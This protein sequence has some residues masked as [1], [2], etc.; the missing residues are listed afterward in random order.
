MGDASPNHP[1]PDKIDEL[2]N[3]WKAYGDRLAELKKA[4]GQ[5]RDITW[6]G[7]TA[8]QSDRVAGQ[9][10]QRITD[11]VNACT[12][13]S[14]SLHDMANGVRDAIKQKK[15]GELISIIM[16]ILGA[17]GILFLAAV[18]PLASALANMARLAWMATAFNAIMRAMNVVGDLIA[19][20]I[21]YVPVIRGA[22][23]AI[24][25]IVNGIV[26]AAGI[27]FGV[28]AGVSVGMGVPFQPDPGMEV[29]NILMGG[30]AGLAFG[31][32]KPIAR[33]SKGGEWFGKVNF[34]LPNINDLTGGLRFGGPR[35]DPSG[36]ARTSGGDSSTSVPPVRLTDQPGPPRVGA[37]ASGTPP[38]P[39]RTTTADIESSTNLHRPGDYPSGH[40]ESATGGTEGVGTTGP[41]PVPAPRTRI[42]GGGPGGHGRPD[43]A[44]G[45]GPVASPRP[46][47]AV[48]GP[49]AR[50][51]QA[52]GTPPPARPV[53]DGRAP[54]ESTASTSGL[55]PANLDAR[56]HTPARI[57]AESIP[58]QPGPG[59]LGAGT[60]TP[61]GPGGP[62]E[63]PPSLGRGPQGSLA[64]SGIGNPPGS[65]PDSHHVTSPRPGTSTGPEA[66]EPRPGRSASGASAATG[67]EAPLADAPRPFQRG[68]SDVGRLD[69]ESARDPITT[70]A[71]L[72]AGTRRPPAHPSTE[73]GS[74]AGVPETGERSLP[75][76]RPGTPVGRPVV[77]GDGPAVSSERPAVSSERA[78]GPAPSRDGGRPDGVA[79]SRDGGRAGPVGAGGTHTAPPAAA[80]RPGPGSG[81]PGGR[82]AVE[83]S[84]RDLTAP[85][86][87]GAGGTD[88]PAQ[89]ATTGRPGGPRTGEWSPD[90]AAQEGPLGDNGPSARPVDG[91]D[92]VV[93]TLD[94]LLGRLRARGLDPAGQ[95]DAVAGEWTRDARRGGQPHHVPNRELA[96][97]RADHGA[98]IE[99]DLAGLFE[100]PRGARTGAAPHGTSP[101]ERPVTVSAAAEVVRG[102]ATA[103]R[104]RLSSEAARHQALDQ[105]SLDAAALGRRHR[106]DHPDALSVDGYRRIADDLRTEL[107]EAVRQGHGPLGEHVRARTG[108]GG[109]DS[110]LRAAQRRILDEYPARIDREVRI[111]REFRAIERELDGYATARG[112]SAVPG[113]QLFDSFRQQVV[114]AE[115]AGLA[116]QLP[117][118]REN[119]RH[120]L[121]RL[122]GLEP[123]ADAQVAAF[124]RENAH[125]AEAPA[126]PA[127]P[128]P[129]AAGPD[130]ARGDHA[131]GIRPL[132]EHTVFVRP[133]ERDRAA[134][135]HGEGSR[136]P[137]VMTSRDLPAVVERDWPANWY[138]RAVEDRFATKW[139]LLKDLNG[140]FLDVGDSP[141]I[142][143]V[144]EPT[145]PGT[146]EFP[147]QIHIVDGDG[148]VRLPGGATAG[149]HAGGDPTN[150]PDR[151]MRLPEPKARP[152]GDGPA[153]G[154]QGDA[155]YWE[156]YKVS[157]S[158]R[159]SGPDG[160]PLG[161]TND[162][163]YRLG[164]PE[165]KPS[166]SDSGRTGGTQ[167]GNFPGE[168]RTLGGDFPGDGRTLGGD[169][170]G[171]GRTS[172]RTPDGRGNQPAG[173]KGG[174]ANAASDFVPFASRGR[175]E[176]PHGSPAGG[177]GPGVGADGRVA[178]ETVGGSPWSGPGRRVDGSPAES[179]APADVPVSQ[180]GIT[181]ARPP[182]GTP[183]PPAEL[184]E[185]SSGGSRRMGGPAEAGGVAP[186]R[187]EVSG[188]RTTTERPDR[189][190]EPTVDNPG[191]SS[192]A[193]HRPATAGDQPP[194]GAPEQR[195]A[196][197]RAVDRAASDSAEVAAVRER[198]AAALERVI[199]ASSSVRTGP[200]VAEVPAAVQEAGG[201]AGDRLPAGAPEQRP[202]GQRAVDRVPSDSAEVAAVRERRAAA[203]ER[204]IAASSSVRTG[205][206]VAEVPAA[207][208]EA[209]GRAG[210]R[211]P[212]QRAVDR[213]PSD[214]AE[215]A[216]VRERRAAALERVIAARSSVRTG[217]PVAE[218]SADVQAAGGRAVDRPAGQRAVDRA[219]SDPAELAAV[220]ER[221]AAAL[222]RAIA[223]AVDRTPVTD[224]TAAG[225]TPAATGR[226]GEAYQLSREA[227]AAR[228]E[229]L[230]EELS[231]SR[232]REAAT[233]RAELRRL[234]MWLDFRSGTATAAEARILTGGGLGSRLHPRERGEVVLAY[235]AFAARAEARL[236]RLLADAVGRPDELLSDAGR[237]I[238]RA[239]IDELRSQLN[240]IGEGENPYGLPEHG[241]RNGRVTGRWSLITE[242]DRLRL[243]RLGGPLTA[244]EDA[245][246]AGLGVGFGEP[247]EFR[248][249]IVRNARVWARQAAATQRLWQ[250]RLEA[251]LSAV[252]DGHG[253]ARVRA[254]WVYYRGEAPVASP[255]AMDRVEPRPGHELLLIDPSVTDYAVI[256]AYVSHLET[257]TDDVQLVRLPGGGPRLTPAEAADL[258]T[259]LLRGTRG[260]LSIPNRRLDDDPPHDGP[261]VPVDAAGRH[262]LRPLHHSYLV[263]PDT[264]PE[265]TPYDLGKT[266]RSDQFALG[267]DDDDWVV[268]EARRGDA[269]DE[270]AVAWFR[271]A[272]L[273][274][275]VTAPALP[276]NAAT[277]TGP[278]IIV[279]VPGLPVPDGVNRRIEAILDLM[280]PER[281]PWVARHGVGSRP[282]IPVAVP[283]GAGLFL[284][285]N[286]ADADQV[287]SDYV[288]AVHLR[289]GLQDGRPGPILVVPGPVDPERQTVGVLG[290]PMPVA[291]LSE[292]VAGLDGPVTVVLTDPRAAV[293]GPAGQSMAELLADGPAALVAAPDP[294]EA[295]QWYEHSAVATTRRFAMGPGST[296]TGRPPM[297]PAQHAALRAAGRAV[298]A[299]LPGAVP[300][301][302]GEPLDGDG[303]VRS[304]LSLAGDAIRAAIEAESPPSSGDR[305]P[306]VET[307]TPTVETIRQHLADFF[308]RDFAARPGHYAAFGIDARRAEE[309]R[310]DLPKP[311]HTG[312]VAGQI[313]LQVAVLA[314]GLNIALLHP[315]GSLANHGESTEDLKI[316]I[317]VGDGDR[318]GYLPGVPVDRPH[319]PT[320]TVGA[321]FHLDSAEP[322]VVEVDT[323]LWEP[324]P[325]TLDRPIP[326]EFTPPEGPDGRP[327]LRRTSG[328]G[329]RTLV[330]YHLSAT[331]QQW[332]VRR[333]LRLRAGPGVGPVEL[334][335]VRRAA[336]AGVRRYF[337]APGHRLDVDGGTPLLRVEL[338]FDSPDP[339][340]VIE[341]V[342]GGLRGMT[343]DRWPV[344]APEEAYAH[345]VGHGLG[346]WH[347]APEN[348]PPPDGGDDRRRWRRQPP[349]AGLM[350][351]G[352]GHGVTPEELARFVAVASPY[353]GSTT[354]NVSAPRF[355]PADPLDARDRTPALLGSEEEF[356]GYWITWADGRPPDGERRTVGTRDGM[357]LD[358]DGNMGVIAEIVA[359]KPWLVL[360][361]ERIG[362]DPETSYREFD[363]MV[364]DLG[365]VTQRMPVGEAFPGLNVQHDAF[366][367][368]ARGNLAYI[369]HTEGIPLEG[370]YW[371]YEE[372]LKFS[373]R[374]E[375][376]LSYAGQEMLREGMQFGR[377]LAALFNGGSAPDLARVSP[378]VT[379]AGYA[380]L[381]YTVGAAVAMGHYQHAKPGLKNY[382]LWAPRTRL[383]GIFKA[384]PEELRSFLEA[385][386]PLIR[387]EFAAT[388]SVDRSWFL[389]GV[390]L[391]NGELPGKPFTVG[392]LL[393]N[394]LL[395]DP[396]KPLTPLEALHIRTFMEEVD[397]NE[398]H[399]RHA[400]LVV[401]E[402][403]MLGEAVM[404]A[405]VARDPM[406]LRRHHGWLNGVARR[407][408][409]RVVATRTAIG[410]GSPPIDLTEAVANLQRQLATAESPPGE[411]ANRLAV[412]RSG[413]L[414]LLR[415]L[416]S[417][418]DRVDLS[419]LAVVL[420]PLPMRDRAEAARAVV[421][422]VHIRLDSTVRAAV[423]RV[424]ASR[425]G[426]TD[427]AIEQ[428]RQ[429]FPNAKVQ[430]DGGRSPLPELRWAQPSDRFAGANTAPVRVDV[431]GLLGRLAELERDAGEAAV[432]W[433]DARVP[434]DPGAGVTREQALRDVAYL[435][436]AVF[437][438]DFSTRDLA[439]MNRLL[440][441]LGGGRRVVHWRDLERAIGSVRG[442]DPDRPT[443]VRP[444][445][446]ELWIAAVAELNRDDAGPDE[447]R[448]QVMGVDEPSGTAAA[449][450]AQR[451]PG[452]HQLLS[453]V[454][455]VHAA[456]RA[457]GMA[458]PSHVT[459]AIELI[460]SVEWD[461]MDW[462]ADKDFPLLLMWAQRLAA[463]P[464]IS[465]D[466]LVAAYRQFEAWVDKLAS[467]DP[468]EV[469]DGV[470]WLAGTGPVQPNLPDPVDGGLMVA[471]PADGDLMPL[472]HAGSAARWEV[473][474][475][476]AL[477]L[478]HIGLLIRAKAERGSASDYGV[479]R[480]TVP[481]RLVPV[482]T[483]QV[484]E[485]R[486]AA[487][488]TD[489]AEI[490]ERL[491][492]GVSL[493]EPV[494]AAVSHPVPGPDAGRN[495]AG[496]RSL[497]APVIV[498][499]D[500]DEP[501]D[502]PDPSSSPVV[503][504]AGPPG[505]DGRERLV[506]L[507]R[508]RMDR[509]APEQGR[510][511]PD[512]F[513][514]RV[515]PPPPEFLSGVRLASLPT[516]RLG[517]F[518]DRADLAWGDRP[519]TTLQVWTRPDGL[520][521]PLHLPMIWL[522]SPLGRDDGHRER[523]VGNAARMAGQL[524]PF[525]VVTTLWI[526]EP[527]TQEM[528]RWA[529]DAGIRLILVDEVFHRDEP[530]RSDQFYRSAMAK[531]IPEG[532]AEAA[533][534]LRWEILLRFGGLYTDG[535]NQV[536]DDDP[537]ALL[538]EL[539]ELFDR[540]GWAVHRDVDGET[541]GNSA[542]MAAR[543]HPVTATFLELI[544]LNYRQP[545]RTMMK[546]VW[547]LF[548][549]RE[550]AQDIASTRA[551]DVRRRSVYW[552]TGPQTLWQLR[553]AVRDRLDSALTGG[554]NLPHLDRLTM[555][556][557]KSWISGSVLTPVRRF[558]ADEEP[559]V[560]YRLAARL[561]RDL[562]NR[563][564]DLRLT[565]A[566]AVVN[567]FADPDNV[568]R[569]LFDVLLGEPRLRDRL[570]SVTDR[571]LLFGGEGGPRLEIVR[572]PDDV[573]TRLGLSHDESAGEP[574]GDWRLGE[575]MR[576][577]RLSGGP[578]QANPGTEDLSR[579]G[580]PPRPNTSGRRPR[581]PR[582]ATVEQVLVLV[583]PRP[584]EGFLAPVAAAA[585][586]LAAA[587]TGTASGGDAVTWSESP[588]VVVG[589]GAGP[590]QARRIRGDLN[591][592]L[593]AY[594]E[595]GVRPVVV[596]AGEPAEGDHALLARYGVPLVRRI[597][598]ET[599]S[600]AG[601]GALVLRGLD[602]LWEVRLP[603][604]AEPAR[605][606]SVG[607]ALDLAAGT[608]V[609]PA[610][611]D[612]LSAELHE[613]LA[614]S[615]WTRRREIFRDRRAELLRPENQ[616]AL[617]RILQRHPAPDLAAGTDQPAGN[618]A[619]VY[620]AIL[621]MAEQTQTARSFEYLTEPD[622]QTRRERLVAWLGSGPD[623]PLEPLV[624]L[625]NGADEDPSY[626]AD[627][628]VLEALRISLGRPAGARGDGP[629]IPPEARRLIMNNR[630]YLRDGND[631]TE[632]ARHLRDLLNTRYPDRGAELGELATLIMSC[633][634]P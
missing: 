573:L 117:A 347:P 220:R 488:R 531:Q 251:R 553:W 329:E 82:P 142:V 249:R 340:Q 72:G 45:D 7:E 167:G 51:G 558:T 606:K 580:Q 298:P 541:Y 279:G 587:R 617:D 574:A 392:Q 538:A 206:P 247:P 371:H 152:V 569:A 133:P 443:A 284:L 367:E 137:G 628:A 33:I 2:A 384:L 398:G 225:G 429:W 417:R 30:A 490:E 620:R 354:P 151:W 342:A 256:R 361:D 110:E 74:S 327:L 415:R 68:Q 630:A 237:A 465:L 561:V 318:T 598:D 402:Y 305:T 522:G 459:E 405:N 81:E 557:A 458:P 66:A 215:V 119:I 44:V 78:G 521:M 42:S 112:G 56:P 200:P 221:R 171:D 509:T 376:Y 615:N 6:T 236:N 517:D 634:Q 287:M 322:R 363:A 524:A 307:R 601:A 622:P 607:A 530:M 165:P 308:A 565:E 116:D 172:G 394:G 374:T 89:P 365:A 317:Q 525:G 313:A 450:L 518:L 290:G 255:T 341:V 286:V 315:D 602:W 334:A 467:V 61:T 218:V 182:A 331:P 621:K 271:P 189:F 17:A 426:L 195:Q 11:M 86:H 168:G 364:R 97:A 416:L 85:A 326:W 520:E 306:S 470:W 194:A 591:G 191:W 246:L 546:D 126:D 393:D 550:A 245:I 514:V 99:R 146:H 444:Q 605:V 462:L 174:L 407:T 149:R 597:A 527:P 333:R 491:G 219:P 568:W 67:P 43:Q 93:T 163:G 1:D 184:A 49:P 593:E 253:L 177:R 202:A 551:M 54:V 575:L 224:G 60:S 582:R 90:R 145:G 38:P 252:A 388:F 104:D 382:L 69:H 264:A 484:S 435:T 581:L 349:A 175:P 455:R 301:A 154:P 147:A 495:V 526:S 386:A 624:E 303:L 106:A 379:L 330:R 381:L 469:D 316:L 325:G 266:P 258:A 513:G 250:E 300:T 554:G 516:D 187:P 53:G 288:T 113:K 283:V 135:E 445:E 8:I 48:N 160:K 566:A 401:G 101:P 299:T 40:F 121:D 583:G 77:P 603:E 482:V 424:D 20:L 586:R 592:A 414:M 616:A 259:S 474:T 108:D 10:D 95:F 431:E 544:E 535:D 468:I 619:G 210:D 272:S 457:A 358:A 507:L 127:R 3:R 543:N 460:L 439:A 76:S 201:R 157:F 239:D 578:A 213:V 50:T 203:L 400:A 352:T 27:S 447:L 16:G 594:Y 328:S 618:N 506:R 248:Y 278:G 166:G 14:E 610:Y 105:L 109:V 281:R 9:I 547:I 534:I 280:A 185:P 190:W 613:W 240:R 232:G 373:G 275:A 480:R 421:E 170:P 59:R 577:V 502:L 438:V 614:A 263:Y 570:T 378:A 226:S 369:Q 296:A 501:V 408:Y 519:A 41:P 427:E 262:T 295:G 404:P 604:P 486:I 478:V 476:S 396:E 504:A 88:A 422:G 512:Y 186:R 466:D 148:W 353:V 71:D 31:G 35:P 596:F 197:Q 21:T 122:L 233:L 22:A 128:R 589:R 461:G 409:Q 52:P 153:D 223:A 475:G 209:G 536:R 63:P 80:V 528:I 511:G 494:P 292:A 432:L 5:A 230:L 144:E 173:A 312:G 65:S 26:W 268:G 413:E 548:G 471:Y 302:A 579:S 483:G 339:H 338:D 75:A 599:P 403:R 58:T 397:T 631:A 169:S 143:P 270:P 222:E 244:R 389:H 370:M 114:N 350:G 24:G 320:A 291:E 559:Q 571:I 100:G 549:G 406:E 372:L 204:V 18:G 590:V 55:R 576:P 595:L 234:R 560:L 103:L 179:A 588:V 297:T 159:A 102:H 418:P 319:P 285:P 120:D 423:R 46:D 136:K 156:R 111:E 390:D 181:R 335:E 499:M 199:A 265:G 489:L 310:R 309:V 497:E 13:M 463:A 79:V 269:A 19:S 39:V 140:R 532:F 337:N 314:F 533:D 456:V 420:R 229:K 293:P 155:Y 479:V 47:T 627:A 357:R 207:V 134:P 348:L 523:F 211:L 216:A 552:R 545:Q 383:S 449:A 625:A 377:W 130:Q 629:I 228:V 537:V 28:Q 196:G 57:G 141:P 584:D 323:D 442:D 37:G 562:Y 399:L 481:V 321:E 366:I 360:D 572:L 125:R 387:N 70:R 472:S 564:G 343:Q 231:G 227:L 257:L 242:A 162:D 556:S 192:T 32:N 289:Q 115:R 92:E 510:L 304:L 345:E 430:P 107:G 243:A 441:A 375:V 492:W 91:A 311:G 214:P 380:T 563:E 632:W 4:T 356:D 64:S 274:P 344:G 260:V 391:L 138:W 241:V 362:A 451:W 118:I 324:L 235:R 124:R 254:G 452:E 385:Y 273:D 139:Y 332:T 164:V 609:G 608:G 585:R 496:Q 612:V 600:A 62:G 505:A 94:D 87:R 359:W 446:V 440:S 12:S 411:A 29:L 158:V 205:P 425:L 355:Q 477:L 73:A 433:R 454:L 282:R 428:V 208:Q 150:P 503:P 212:G 34:D 161:L 123:W 555:G 539:R 15:A 412:I 453:A 180:A 294:A 336:E 436:A 261:F 633:Y 410:D 193:R 346:L 493:G 434:A 96:R 540:H 508:S 542:I 277:G 188:S 183:K 368:P 529:G 515:P 217:P 500:V 487:L 84:S 176:V 498:V 626:G 267:V 25:S 132:P 448:R 276:F 351:T 238:R 623:V 23:S 131:G 611:G 98:A 437:G 464:E 83:A 178:R 36:R 198:R 419:E 485:E 129:S 395:R 567:G 473:P